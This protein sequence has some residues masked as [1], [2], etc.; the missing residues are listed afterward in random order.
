M[1]RAY[2]DE[3]SFILIQLFSPVESGKTLA[4]ALPVMQM[5]KHQEVFGEVKRLKQRPRAVILAPTRELAAQITTVLKQLSHSIKLSVRA[6][7]GNDSVHKQRK[8][9]T[10]REVDVLVATPGR[11][12]QHVNDRTVLLN[13]CKFVVLDEMDTMIEQGFGNEL[14]RLLHPVLYHKNSGTPDPETELV[15]SAPSVWLTSATMTQSI[16]K[17]IGD[18]S[19][20]VN[21]KRHYV[22]KSTDEEKRTTSGLV[23][24]RMEVLRAPGLHKV[25]PKLEQVFVDVGNVNKLSLLVD[26]VCSESD[27]QTLIFCN[28]A[29]SCR[30]V[31]YALSEAR[32]SCLSYHGDL[33]SI[34]RAE[35]FDQFRKGT[36]QLLVC[37]DLAARGLDVPTVQHVIMFDFPLNA[38]D[39]LHRSGRTARGMNAGKVTAMVTKRDQVLAMAIER[40]VQ[41]GESLDGLSSRKSDYQLGGRL[42]K[43]GGTKSSNKK[44]IR[45][46]D[47]SKTNRPASRGA[48]ARRQRR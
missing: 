43:R 32:L 44:T 42:H 29:N 18:T 35:N 15:E 2:D 39:Y 23:L 10:A 34:A 19:D 17:M 26:L 28:T 7:T 8:Y 27:K 21:A 5:L 9:L 45:V 48:P 11:L 41:R 47:R 38:L 24:P 20:S 36:S 40:A 25:V 30:A 31:E 33:N 6:V 12:I 37:T 13:K 4:Y 1:L 3:R 14:A 16:Q 46:G 22:K